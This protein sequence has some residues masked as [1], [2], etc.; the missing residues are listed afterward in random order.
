MKVKM[1]EYA[2]TS[3]WAAKYGPDV[4]AQVL[5][6]LPQIENE[7]LIVGIETSDDAAVY[8]INNELALIQTLDFFTPIVDDPLHYG[9]IAAANS[10]SDVYAMGGEPIIAMN[11][12]CFPTCLDPEIL[13]QILIGGHEKV[14]EAGCVLAG[15]HTV[16]D[17]EPKYGLSVSGFVHPNKIWTN[18]NCKEGDLLVLTKPI[19]TGVINTALKGGISDKKLE[20]E[21][22]NTMEELNKYAK[23]YSESF[24]INSCTDVTGF[25]L[26]GHLFEM[27]KGSNCSINLFFKDIPVINGTFELLNYGLLPEGAYNNKDFVGDNIEYKIK[28]TD[29]DIIFDPQTSGGLLLSLPKEEALELNIVLRNNNIKSAIIGEVNKFNGKYL[30]LV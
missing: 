15:G 5:C 16:Q 6:K 28:N 24:N 4:L 11:I 23:F 1:T 21:S 8:K 29:T 18:S 12:V 7:N 9:R 14:N 3:G 22:I 2:K 30:Y 10:L 26:A 17:D 19:G 20:K 25:G 27:A 13:G